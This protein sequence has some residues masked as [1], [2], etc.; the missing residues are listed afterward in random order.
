MRLGVRLTAWFKCENRGCEVIVRVR[1]IVKVNVRARMRVK[2]T[3][4]D[5][6]CNIR[7]SDVFQMRVKD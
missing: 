3:K 1:M 7:W 4:G 6:I 5:L 2:K